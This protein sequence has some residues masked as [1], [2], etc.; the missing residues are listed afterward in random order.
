M[1]K[2]HLGGKRGS[3]IGNY[4]VV[5]DEDYEFLNQWKWCAQVKRNASKLYVSPIR[6]LR[7]SGIKQNVKM[8]RQI[9]GATYPEIIVDHIDGNPLNNQK[10][11]LRLCLAADNVKNARKSKKGASSKYRGVRWFKPHGKWVAKITVNKLEIFIGY[12][13]SEVEAALA[14][15]LAATKHHGEFASL[16]TI[17][18]EDYVRELLRKHNIAPTQR[19]L[20]ILAEMQKGEELVFEKGAGWWLGTARIH[21][22]TIVALQRLMSISMDQYS[23]AAM[24]R[25][26]IN[27]TGKK[28][29]SERIGM[30]LEPA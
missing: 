1:K 6:N 9:L 24:E 16:N 19:Q 7:V 15:N 11:N 3:I 23:T 13:D 27:E 22:R 26:H 17:T 2:I 25:Y 20:E 5:D 30:A 8:S 14:Y 10:S 21:G 18:E 29:L 12:F 4:A 28:L